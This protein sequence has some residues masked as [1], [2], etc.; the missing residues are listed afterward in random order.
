MRDLLEMVIVAGGLWC[1]RISRGREY[2]PLQTNEGRMLEA[3]MVLHLPKTEP[4]LVRNEDKSDSSQQCLG[5]LD[6]LLLEYTEE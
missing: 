2:Q 5:R 1:W 4:G 6:Q 3:A